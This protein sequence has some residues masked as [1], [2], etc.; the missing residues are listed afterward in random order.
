MR[1]RAVEG[2][3]MQIFVKGI[4]GKTHTLKVRACS[5]VRELKEAIRD[6]TE[7]PLDK[8]FLTYSGKCL[9]D[10]KPLGIYGI[11]RDS[12]LFMSLRLLSGPIDGQG[13]GR[14]KRA[15]INTS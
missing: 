2:T 8:F 15:K 10:C 7:V 9:Q 12:T 3:L 13:Q 14:E 11:S 6:A 4:S 1:A 5:S